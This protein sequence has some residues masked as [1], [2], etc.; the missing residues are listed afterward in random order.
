MTDI[1]IKRRELDRR[2]KTVSEFLSLYEN[3]NT[4]RNY[5]IGVKKF[6]LFFYPS[7][8]DNLDTLSLRYF[9]EERDVE[10]DLIIFRDEILSKLAPTTRNSHV[11]ALKLFFEDNNV[12]FSRRV[13]NQLK[14]MNNKPISWENTPSNE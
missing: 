5:R 2:V 8:K 14:A 6:L 3:V 4:K 11:N 10:R 9:D 1:C 7:S 12:T 13:L